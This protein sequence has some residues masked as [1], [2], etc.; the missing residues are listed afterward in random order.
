MKFKVLE[1]TKEL[2]IAVTTKFSG[3]QVWWNGYQRF[4][5]KFRAVFNECQ[6]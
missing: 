5:D 1:D 3:D 2:Q 6:K 4:D